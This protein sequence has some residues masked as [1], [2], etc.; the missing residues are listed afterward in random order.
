[1]NNETHLLLHGIY[2]TDVVLVLWSG[3]CDDPL[4]IPRYGD[5]GVK[6]RVRTVKHGSS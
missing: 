1:M 2:Y 6:K 3:L 5:R 4:L